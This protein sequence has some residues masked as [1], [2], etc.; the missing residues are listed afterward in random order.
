VRFSVD[1]QHLNQQAVLLYEEPRRMRAQVINRAAGDFVGTR[2]GRDDSAACPDL[3]TQTIDGR[4]R[5]NPNWGKPL[6]STLA[7]Q[8]PI[9][10]RFGLALAF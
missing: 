7:Y 10:L 6:N 9:Q 2:S 3:A 1:V 8:T 5:V 4:P